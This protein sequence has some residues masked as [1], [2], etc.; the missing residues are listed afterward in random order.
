MAEKRY[1]VYGKGNCI[2]CSL[3]CDFLT[4]S[5]K[6]YFFFDH[7]GDNGTL[8]RLKRFY[9]HAT[10]PIILENSLETGLTKLIGGYSDLI[11]SR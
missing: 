2:F 9:N 4:A 11:K 10:F 1:F 6:E 7:Q 3:A 8:Q 5:K